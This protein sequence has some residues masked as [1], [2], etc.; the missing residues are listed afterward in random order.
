MNERV[1]LVLF[2]VG[3]ELVNPVIHNVQNGQMHF[4]NLAAFAD[5]I[6]T[7]IS[8]TVFHK[9]LIGPFLNALCH[10]IQLTNKISYQWY[11]Q[12]QQAS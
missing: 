5:F 6:T 9:Y 12:K 11:L 1:N 4:K 2:I 8:K 7:N 3:F 10:M